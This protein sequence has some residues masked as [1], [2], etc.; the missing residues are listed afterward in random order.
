MTESSSDVKRPRFQGILRPAQHAHGHGPG[1]HT[2]GD[3]RAG[4]ALKF[5]NPRLERG[6]GVG[7]IVYFDCF[8][9]VAGDMTVAALID[10][11]VPL[12]VVQDAVAAVG[13]AGIQ[14]DVVPAQTGVI[15]GVRFVVEQRG[16]QP[17]RSYAEIVRLLAAARFDDDTR[18]RAQAIF[19]RLARGQKPSCIAVRSK[20]CR[21]TRWVPSTQ[22]ADVV[23]A[24]AAARLFGRR[25]D[26]LAL[27]NGPRQHRVPARSPAVAGAGNRRLPARSSDLR[28]R[29]RSGAR[30]PDG[31][32]HRCFTI[33]T[34]RALAGLVAAGDRLGCRYAPT[35]GSAQRAARHPRLTGLARACRAGTAP[36]RATPWWMR[37]WR[38]SQQLL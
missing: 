7:K 16:R 22:C 21:S 11:G 32:C 23:G 6:A 9:G 3:A 14:L 38:D 33:G 24:A 31:C 27:A 15:G 28:R 29:G 35:P 17:E 20:R 18:A 1:E 12:D 25:A 36:S 2:H 10:L 5:G 8:S 37:P 19:R 34:L 30:H 26:L 4:D 13:I